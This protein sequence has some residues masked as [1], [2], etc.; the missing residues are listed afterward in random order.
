[1]FRR[2]ALPSMSAEDQTRAPAGEDGPPDGR[3]A[4]VVEK[5]LQRD[6]T[7]RSWLPGLLAA[8]PRGRER[9]GEL[10]ERPGTLQMALSMRGLSG[11]RGCLEMRAPPPPALLRWF[12]EHPERLS[13]PPSPQLTSEEAVLRRALIADQPPGSRPRAQ[14]RAREALVERS[15]LA[16]G[17]WRFEQTARLD[18]ILMTE[19]LVLAIDG[20]GGAALTPVSEWYPQRPRLVRT[21]EGAR[22]LADGR[23]W[24]ALLTGEEK[25]P[26]ASAG[27]LAERLPEAA[28]HL[29]AAGRAD[30]LGG[31]LGALTWAEAVAALSA[32]EAEM[33]GPGAGRLACP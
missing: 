3:T 13:W 22:G 29:D 6:A 1:M 15:A 26:D 12:I 30:L 21:L 9:L 31:Y 27:W 24:A 10:V 33:D 8:S 32:G 28:P 14:E 5:L 20:G 25:L 7:G 4:A 16:C 2:V 19:D 17:W 23:A 11:R 18:C